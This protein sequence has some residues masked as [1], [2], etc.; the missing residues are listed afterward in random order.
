MRDYINGVHL[1]SIATKIIDTD[2]RDDLKYLPNHSIIWCKTEFIDVVFSEIANSK[3]NHKL[4]THCSDHPIDEFRFSKKP[5]NVVKWYAQNVDYRHE[6]LIPIPIGI[7]N[8]YGPHRGNS[9]DYD[10]LMYQL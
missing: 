9:I 5:S 4:I 8:H 6:D 3:Y 1:K 2:R 7:E 10:Y